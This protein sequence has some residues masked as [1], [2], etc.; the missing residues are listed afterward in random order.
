MGQTPYSRTNTAGDTLIGL[1]NSYRL[2]AEYSLDA[3]V[4]RPIRL[5]G[6]TGGVY[7]DA[8]NLLNRRN[9][10][11]V[12]RDSGQP[13][14][15]SGTLQTLALQAYQT[16]PEPIP[17][18]SPRYRPWADLDGNGL[19]EGAGELVPLYLAAA[20]DFAQPLFYF[21]AP[22]LIRMGIELTF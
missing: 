5:G 11:A 19:L 3:L 1:P 6:W 14:L 21:G 2:P 16:H 22:R 4:R 9:T 17:Y 13:G 15:T 8:R 7:V 12:R 20:R 10:V 18:E